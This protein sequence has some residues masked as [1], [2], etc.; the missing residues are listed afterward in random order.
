MGCPS[1][2]AVL[3]QKLPKQPSGTCVHIRWVAPGRALRRL[4][5]RRRLGGCLW[6]GKLW[7]TVLEL[8][9]LLNLHLFARR[10]AIKRSLNAPQVVLRAHR[11][12]SR[13]HTTQDSVADAVDLAGARGNARCKAAAA[14]AGA[15]YLA[16][17]L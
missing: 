8:F 15:H 7:E 13:Q 2:Q 11:F 3:T 16:D 14:G 6:A 10:Q 12:H 5:R 4:G 1:R 17:A 9:D